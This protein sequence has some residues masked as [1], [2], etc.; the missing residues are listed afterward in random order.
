MVHVI[1]TNETKS[2]NGLK[3]D[4]ICSCKSIESG[5]IF[6]EMKMN[7]CNKNSTTFIIVYQYM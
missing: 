2:K 1:A 3:S 7:Y 5:E 6:N 4:G